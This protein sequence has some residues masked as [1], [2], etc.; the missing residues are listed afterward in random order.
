MPGGAEK[1]F[2]HRL[3][4]SRAAGRNGHWLTSPSIA[5]KLDVLGDIFLRLI[6]SILAPLMFA[7]LVVGVA[8]SGKCR[9]RLGRV[10]GK[11]ILRYFK[12]LTTIAL[13]I[14]A[15]PPL[16][17]LSARL[18]SWSTAPTDLSALPQNATS[19]ESG[20]GESFPHQHHRRNEPRRR[21]ANR[22]LL[23]ALSES[24]APRWA[25]VQAPVV[26]FCESLEQIM[27]RY[28]HYVMFFAPLGIFGASNT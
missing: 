17:T 5:S 10:G 2:P 9:S 14:G 6:A 27:F 1:D 15:V 28:T 11:A 12:I 22:G 20:S 24:P 18:R 4:L 26:Q 19:L 25:S 23:A 8:R 21:S 13:V 3:D 7:S 16:A